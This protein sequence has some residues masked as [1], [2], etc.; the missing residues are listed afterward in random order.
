MCFGNVCEYGVSSVC[1]FGNVC[2]CVGGWVNVDMC[3]FGE[4]VG[5][6]VGGDSFV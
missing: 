2:L 1:V 3:F 4:C 6:C 5:G